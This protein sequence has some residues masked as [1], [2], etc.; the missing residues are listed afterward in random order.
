MSEK[1]SSDSLLIV[2][3]EDHNDFVKLRQMLVRTHMEDLREMTNSVLYENY[4]AQKLTSGSYSLDKNGEINPLLKFEDERAAHETKMTKLEAE[5][6]QV[7][8]MKVAEKE[9]KMRQNEEELYAKHRELRESIE[10]QR[11]EL[12]EKKRRLEGEKKKTK[13][14][15]K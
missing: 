8:Q 13:S 6:K 2:D 4:R 3:N 5:M 12:E 7:F 1:P 15:F 10:R 9:A 14:L 11:M